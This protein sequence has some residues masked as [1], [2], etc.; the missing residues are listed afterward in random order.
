MAGA[1]WNVVPGVSAAKTIHTREKPAAGRNAR[2]CMPEPTCDGH[3]CCL[4]GRLPV[5]RLGL[6]DLRPSVSGQPLD[7]GRRH[8]DR[9]SV[10]V[11]LG[12]DGVV[13]RVHATVG[14]S[15]VLA[16]ALAA[17]MLAS[18][19][20]PTAIMFLLLIAGSRTQVPMEALL[21]SDLV[22]SVGLWWLYG[23]VSGAS[24]VAYAVVSV[25]P[26][27]VAASSA[28]VL[29]AG[30]VAVTASEVALHLVADQR[31]LPLFHPPDP[32]PQ[33]E[34]FVGV[35]VQ[36]SLLLGVGVLMLQLA[37]SLRAGKEA[38]AADLARQL[39][40]HDL[41]DRFLATVSHELRTPLT[42]IRGFIGVLTDESPGEPQRG[43]YLAVVAEQTEQ[44]HHLVED[45]IAFNRLEA[46]QLTIK[47]EPVRFRA[48]VE[49]VL[50][51]FG[52]RARVVEL[53][54]GADLVVMADPM[55][56][57][58]VLRNLLDNA[59][60]YGRAPVWISAEDADGWL[61]WRLFDHGPGLAA[62]E[63]DQAFE[64]YSRFVSNDT[65]SQPGIG[66]GLTIVRELVDA[67]GGSVR[68][69]RERGFEVRLP[70]A[71]FRRIQES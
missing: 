30:A 62:D 67:H 5:T 28:R 18:R 17:P 56:L 36:A 42:A 25:A 43:E 37:K 22:L 41:K 51:G 2:G 19:A 57:A 15:A 21:G 20:W 60:K 7:L 39:E 14:V 34:F 52:D 47:H 35:G 66:L 49:S 69:T 45:V 23:P 31:A 50:R 33:A 44:M 64:P 58:Q 59:F 63:V 10:S 71:V 11:E 12:L 13:R 4:E 16:V 40:L 46:G 8:V 29:L 61:T 48:A 6:S 53:D 1:R 54:I 3:R 26:L 9:T 55:R 24:F 70:G 32:I 68:Y 27:V 65:M 38:L